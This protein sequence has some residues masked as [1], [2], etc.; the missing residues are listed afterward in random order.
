MRHANRRGPL[1]KIAPYAAGALAVAAAVALYLNF[2]VVRQIRLDFSAFTELFADSGRRG[3]PGTPGTPGTPGASDEELA[4]EVIEG[5][6]V[7]GVPLPSSID[8]ETPETPAE[9]ADAPTPEPA[10]AAAEPATAAEPPSAP[11]S[12]LPPAALEPA[13][14]A[15][16]TASTAV[17]APAPERTPAPPPE[18]ELPVGPETF[19]FGLSSVRVSEADASAA[20]IV[21]R[22][23]GRRGVSSVRWWTTDGTAT[24]GADYANLGEVVQQFAVGE[25]NRT[26]RIPIIGDRNVEGSE[27]FYVHLAAGDD[28]ESPGSSPERLEVVINDDD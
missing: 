3:A 13:N 25:Q 24:A 14:E 20:V 27:T 2:D 6:G 23:G 19:H 10:T 18:P 12:E 7:A 15:P 17:P 4:T 22:D 16:A 9:A 26:I 28:A 8:G 21:L 5:G 11:S 1:G